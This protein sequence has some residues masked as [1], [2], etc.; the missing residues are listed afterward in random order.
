MREVV[1]LTFSSETGDSGGLREAAGRVRLEGMRFDVFARAAQRLP[2]RARAVAI[3]V[4]LGLVAGAAAVAFQVA[5]NFAYGHGIEALTH[6]STAAFLAGSFV[7]LAGS[8]AGSGWLLTRFCPEAAGSGIP[9][10]KLAFWKDLGFVPWRVV[11]VKFVGGVL[12]VGGGNS[13]GR[14]GPSV[15]LAGGLASNVAGWLGTPKQERRAAAAAGAAAGL[16]AAF[17]T[18]LAAVT[19]VLEEI[20]GDLN[21]RM[22]G[23]VLL[24]A[25]LGALVAHGLVGAQPAFALHAPGAPLWLGYALTPVVAAAA[26]LM[27]VWFQHAT[28]GLRR[29]NQRAQWQP[30][31]VR[32]MIGGIAVWAIGAAVFVTT[33]HAGVFSLGYGDLSQALDGRMVWHLAALLLVAKLAATAVCYGL[34]GCGGIFAPT[35]FFGAMT[36]AALAG[37]VGLVAPLTPADNVTLAV[38]GMAACLGAVVRAPV[39]GILIVFEMTHEFALVPALMIGALVS[40]VIARRMAR[41][42]FYEAVLEQDGQH[43]DRIVP[44]RDL[45]SWMSAPVGRI[46][47][48][49]PVIARDLSPAGLGE[50][51]AASGHE[52][53]P[54]M[55][56]DRIAGVLA[57]AEAEAAAKAG[58]APALEPAV[59]CAADAPLREVARQIVA[60]P[61]GLAVV[62]DRV[63]EGGRPI[64]LLTMHDIL[65]AQVAQAE[66]QPE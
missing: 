53:F 14:E 37:L 52:R 24:A 63:G 47:N 3:A 19:F 45:K 33:G 29:R 11:W 54:V 64:G 66:E 27:G 36:G 60:S 12:S 38:V 44:P 31:W 49:S 16:A 35:L 59:T 5:I 23:G 4:V 17:N 34:G 50:L 2:P 40:Q 21:S 6:R 55:D 51:L 13:L 39:T 57:R 30:A 56:G 41:T 26:A 32:T 25:V 28:L 7:L 20:I 8:A 58:R 43:I 1:R 15:Q 46:A 65:R 42:N 9:Q 10:L 22:L 62:V 18:P 48:F 61:S